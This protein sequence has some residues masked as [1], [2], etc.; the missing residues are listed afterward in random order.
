M[1]SNKSI[2]FVVGDSYAVNSGLTYVAKNMKR[3]LETMGYHVVYLSVSGPKF[4]DI[5]GEAYY[6]D[7]SIVNFD[8]C[9]EAF[10]P[11]L[12]FTVHDLW[13]LVMTVMSSYRDTYKLIMYCPIEASYYPETVVYSMPDNKDS[14]SVVPIAQ[15]ARAADYVIAYNEFGAKGLK[16]MNVKVDSAIHN[17]LDT[18]KNFIISNKNLVMEKRRSLGVNDNDV[19]FLHVSRNSTRKR[20][21]VLLESWFKFIEL[22]RREHGSTSTPAAKLYLHVEKYA[23][24]GIDIPAIIKRFRIENSVILTDNVNVSDQEMNLL[25]N[26]CDVYIGLPGGEGHG[27]GFAEA[28]ITG[29][30]V[31]YGDYGGQTTFCKG[32]GISVPPVQ[33]ITSQNIDAP[34]AI[35]NSTAAAKAIEHLYK[36]RED[37]ERFGNVGLDF[38]TRALTWDVLDSSFIRSIQN[39]VSTSKNMPFFA[40]RAV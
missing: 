38:A 15:V 5:Q 9:V 18:N 34:R 14:V 1:N 39:A 23:V 21:D 12:V 20:Q 6:I 24:N 8:R 36:S 33:F 10:R 25:Y 27:Y 17:G 29:K 4:N 16:S 31:I 3:I 2:A 22:H 28:M 32:A 35:I 13:M 7:N 30:P 19:M 26:A 37:R 40:R 11:E